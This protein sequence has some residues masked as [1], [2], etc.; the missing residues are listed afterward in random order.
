MKNEES[1]GIENDSADENEPELLIDLDNYKMFIY[2]SNN[3]DANPYA[4]A[5]Q[6]ISS[7]FSST[8]NFETNLKVDF[9]FITQNCSFF[10]S[11]TQTQIKKEK[12]YLSFFFVFFFLFPNQNLPKN[13]WE[14]RSEK[15]TLLP[16]ITSVWI[17]KIE[18]SSSTT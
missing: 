4:L 18:T 6:S 1:E 8:Y 3:H 14:L 9:N 13:V 11:Q 17:E 15:K 16:S 2:S 12:K 5:N 10:F 7:C